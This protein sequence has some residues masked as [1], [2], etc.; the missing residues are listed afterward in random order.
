MLMAWGRMLALEWGEGEV[1]RSDQI[2]IYSIFK[3]GLTGFAKG[4]TMRN[5]R[6]KRVK[7]DARVLS[8]QLE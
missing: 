8:E 5:E 3:V 4:L 2:C 7:D 1:V 6:K